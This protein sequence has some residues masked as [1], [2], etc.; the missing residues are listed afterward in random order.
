MRCPACGHENPSEDIYCGECGANLVVDTAHQNVERD[1]EDYYTYEWFGVRYTYAKWRWQLG[2]AFLGAVLIIYALVF[3]GVG[4]YVNA[5]ILIAVAIIGIFLYH[6][7][8]ERKASVGALFLVGL[9]IGVGMLAGVQPWQL[10]AEES[11]ERYMAP[12]LVASLTY[13]VDDAHHVVVDGTITNEGRTGCYAYVQ[14]KA[15]G[16]YSSNPDD[17][18]FGAFNQ[19]TVTTSW[20]A[21]GGG[22]DSISWECTLSYF[23]GY[24]QVTWTVEP[25][26]P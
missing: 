11:H 14:I 5:I 2:V 15:Y 24:G 20:L 13:T 9:V 17:D 25:S 23:N 16:G 1:D 10:W 4:W 6:E 19:G 7:I 26:S 21:P 12:R 22:S 18:M 3:I 8:G